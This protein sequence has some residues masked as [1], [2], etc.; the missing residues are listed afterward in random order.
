MG[1]LLFTKQATFTTFALH[2]LVGNVIK[3]QCTIGRT[4]RVILEMGPCG[5]G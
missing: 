5:Y 2:G 3:K 4:D 1:L